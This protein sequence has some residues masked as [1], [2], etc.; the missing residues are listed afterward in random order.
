MANA[1]LYGGALNNPH[2]ISC[3]L[4]KKRIECAIG[5]YLSER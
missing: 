4:M 5:I 1:V 2:E 3:Q